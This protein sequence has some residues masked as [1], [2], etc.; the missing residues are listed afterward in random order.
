MKSWNFSSIPLFGLAVLALLVFPA[1]TTT[2]GT[3]VDTKTAVTN[4]ASVAAP[5]IEGGAR[6]AVPIILTKNP[7]LADDFALSTSAAATILSASTPTAEGFSAA[8]RAAFPGVTQAQAT[9]IGAALESAYAA[10]AALFKA[11]TGRDLVLTSIIA[12]PEY[13][14]AADSLVTALVR[15]VA[16]G[17]ADYRTTLPQS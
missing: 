10:G 13:K 7:Q 17:L 6:I 15:G 5:L 12:D 8:V 16:N 2:T 4:A 1:C 11:Q 14:A 3:R 9:Q